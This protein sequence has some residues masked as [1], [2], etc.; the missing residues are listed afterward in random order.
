MKLDNQ[1]PKHTIYERFCPSN[2]LIQS[3]VEN[4]S[5]KHES[6][7]KY[8]IMGDRWGGIYIKNHK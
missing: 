6:T 4:N 1:Y 5:E 8:K 3:P 7:K 2:M